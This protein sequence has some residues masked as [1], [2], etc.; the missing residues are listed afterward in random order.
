MAR[1]LMRVYLALAVTA[2]LWG[3]F[4]LYEHPLQSMKVT[5]DGV[6][7]FTPPVIDPATGQ[8]VSVETLVRHYKGETK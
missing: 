8:T 4:R 2:C 3:L 6:P 5:R 1:L 7:Y